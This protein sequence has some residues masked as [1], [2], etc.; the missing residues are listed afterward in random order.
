MDVVGIGYKKKSLNSLK[1]NKMHLPIAILMI[2]ASIAFFFAGLNS[3]RD[4]DRRNYSLSWGIMFAAGMIQV[5]LFVIVD[6]QGR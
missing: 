5:M 3:D 2:T 1:G 6:V 4:N